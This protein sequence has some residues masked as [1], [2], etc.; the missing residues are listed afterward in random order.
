MRYA[1]TLIAILLSLVTLCACQRGNSPVPPDSAFVL[2]GTFSEQTTVADLEVRFG[3]ANI[4]IVEEPGEDDTRIR[5]VL[6]FP[7]DPSRRAYVGFHDSENL[8]GL[9]SISVRDAGSRW[10]GKQGVY[11][12]MSFA[13]LHKRNGKPFGLAG[14]DSQYRAWAHDQWSPARDDDDNQLGALDVAEGEHMYFGVQLG[15]RGPVKD[16]P[17]GAYPVDDSISSDDPRYPRLG[18][19]VV[20][21]EIHATTSLDDEW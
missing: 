14:F 18:E 4:R 10:R 7:D 11:V 21:T 20:V 8:S 9:A 17:A 12:G 15:L 6:L 16:I 3:K 2:P 1:Q 5:S 13:E 19:I